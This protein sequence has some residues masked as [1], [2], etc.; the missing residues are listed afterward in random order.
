MELYILDTGFNFVG[1]IDSYESVLW[2][3]KYN[4]TGECE[5]Y[6]P[7]EDTFLDLLKTGNYVFRYDDD[8]FCR[9]DRVE[10]QTDVEN[11]D[12]II[13]TASD[14][15]TIL[16]KRIVRWQVVY[17]GKAAAFIKKVITDNVINP[18]QTNRKISNLI[19]DDSN[20]SDFTETMSVTA[21]A[22]DL[23]QLVQSTCKAFNYGFR[24]SYS[25]E[26]EKLVCRLYKGV[27]KSTGD[28][29]EYVV[30]SPDYSNIISSEYKEDETNLKNIAYVGY[31]TA[32]DEFKMLSLY[33]GSSE[34]T[35]EA[36]REIYV[37]GTGTSRSITVDELQAIFNNNVQRNPVSGGDSGVYYISIGEA[38]VQVVATFKASTNSDGVYE[39]KITVTDYTY[40]ILI[41]AIARNTLAEHLTTTSF[42]GDVDTVNT[43]E[44]KTDYNLGDIVKVEN[45]YGI[46]AQARITE[47][48][49]SD[50]TDNGYQVEPKFEY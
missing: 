40:L 22:D 23:L 19:F 12:H 30:F 50:D 48:M 38:E 1:V 21:V 36:R 18:E 41:R 44:Y 4:D 39:E 29:D 9:I 42:T 17:S 7:C 16:S 2:N 49:E 45:D 47:I 35:G 25:P 20:F 14:I 31:K 10:I 24:I 28:S 15:C 11:G 5:I 37:D 8:M 32:D 26:Q 6:V 13:A 27:D 34:P 43:Y 33:T 46:E 3:K